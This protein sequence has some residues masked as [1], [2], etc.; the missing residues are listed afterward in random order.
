[1]SQQNTS[2]V[3]F[4][5]LLVIGVIAIIFVSGVA[6]SKKGGP[7]PQAKRRYSRHIFRRIAANYGLDTDQTDILE[8]LVKATKVKQPFLVF[9]NSG[10]LDDILKKGVYSFS[11]NRE[12]STEERDS[13]L[14]KLFKIKES[15]ERNAKKGAGVS[16]THVIRPGQSVMLLLPDESQHESRVLTNLQRMLVC[17]LPPGAENDRAL[18][19]RGTKIGILF[20]KAHDSGYQFESKIIGFDNVKGSQSILLQHNSKTLKK[21]QNR[22]SKRKSFVRNCYFYP[23]EIM[24]VGSGRKARKKAF[25]QDRFKHL[26]T[27]QDISSGG[28]CIV[29]R[30]PLGPGKLLMMKFEVKKGETITAYGKIRRIG[31]PKGELPSM[32]IKFTKVTSHNLNSIYSFVYDFSTPASAETATAGRLTGRLTRT[33]NYHTLSQPRERVF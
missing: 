7:S 20:Y 23:I 13:K 19:K 28:C 10:L 17:A 3:I 6:I 11:R 32:H 29:S 15:I 31:T 24:T 14:A 25:V 9:T 5:I 33:S 12:I 18:W 1:M 27:F 26:G 30:A 16:S 4:G 2:A 22:K 21:N 8:N